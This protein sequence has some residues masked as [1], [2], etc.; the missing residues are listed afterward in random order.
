LELVAIGLC[1]A[2]GVDIDALAAGALELVALIGGILVARR[3]T[4]VAGQ[5]G[6]LL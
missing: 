4:R 3:Y 2:G 5:N 1:A 6:D